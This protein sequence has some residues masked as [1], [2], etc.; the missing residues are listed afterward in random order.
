MVPFIPQHQYLCHIYVPYTTKI[1]DLKLLPID[2]VYKYIFPSLE[3]NHQPVS[4]VINLY[5]VNKIKP[6]INKIDSK[7]VQHD[8]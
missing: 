7:Y 1:K 6:K 5:P 8:G 3:S 4:A 2:K